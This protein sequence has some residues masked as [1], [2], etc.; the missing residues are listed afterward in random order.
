MTGTMKRHAL[1]YSL[2]GLALLALPSLRSQVRQDSHLP[3]FVAG[4]PV[5]SQGGLLYFVNTTSDTVVIGACENGNPGCSLRGAIQAAN[6]HAGADG[7]LI[8]LGL[9]SFINLMQP[10]PNITGSVSI[11]GPGA[12]LVT[13]RRSLAVTGDL[14]IFTITATPVT[15]S[16]LTISDGRS[17]SGG[18]EGGNIRNNTG[19]LTITACVINGGTAFFGG[20]IYNG[21]TLMINNST[22]TDNHGGAG[23][24][25]ATGATATV[26]GCT[27]SFNAGDSA[28]GIM[29]LTASST[30]TVINS[31]ISSNQSTDDAGGGIFNAGSGQVNISGSTLNNNTAHGPGGGIA[32]RAG[33]VMITNSTISDNRATSGTIQR[34]GGIFNANGLIDIRGSTINGNMAGS[35]G[36]GIDNSPENEFVEAIVKVTNCT[37]SHN[38]AAAGGGINNSSVGIVFLTNSTVAGNTSDGSPGAGLGGGGIA[39]GPGAFNVKSTILALNSAAAGPNAFGSIQSQGFNLVAIIDGSTGWGATGDQIGT[40]IS[41]INPRLETDGLANPVLQNNGGPTRTIILQ[42]GS[43]A[44]DRGASTGLTGMLTTDQ[45]GTGFPRAAD[46][47][48]IA[49]A[50][51]GDGTDVG[52]V[53]GIALK[54][55]SIIRLTNGHILLQGLGIPSRAHKIEFS[56]DLSSNSFTPFATMPTADG[57]GAIQYDDATAVGLPKQFYRLRFP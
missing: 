7:I 19:S 22:V 53:E 55:T 44:L 34:G 4:G 1:S 35:F 43:P 21:G 18:G 16:G 14:R 39:N 11:T 12:N 28:G 41:P 36:G 46:Y 26:N 47:T 31:T 48:N 29:N 6:A 45:R 24:F 30:L 17:L 13:V 8:D 33:T 20:G 32:S 51:T 2:I 50:V 54:I 23:I 37:I 56:P 5:P 9:S 27:I 40:G 10:L 49:N 25:N 15:I 57:T 3:E 38:S 42:A 52:A